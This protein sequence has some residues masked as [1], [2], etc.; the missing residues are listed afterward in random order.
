MNTLVLEKLRKEFLPLCDRNLLYQSRIHPLRTF[1]TEHAR[2]WVKR[3]DE[4]GFGISGCKKRKYAS[5]IPWLK[6]EGFRQVALIGGTRSNHISGFLQLLIE[7]GLGFRL[8]L[9]AEH[10]FQ[11]T[12]NRLLLSLLASPESITFIPSDQWPQ[13]EAIAASWAENQ[14]A[15]TAVIP[16]GGSCVQA[17]PGSSTLLLD[18]LRNEQES[19]IEFDQILIDAGT[20]WMAGTLGQLAACT[21]YRAT[22]HVAM[23]A[24]DAESFSQQIQLIRKYITACIGECP[25][26]RVV[27]HPVPVAKSFGSVNSTVLKEVYSMAREDGILADPVYSAKLFMLARELS[28]TGK[29]KGNV[30]VIHSGGGTGLMGWGEKIQSYI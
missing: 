21:D 25:Q 15:L 9:K 3:E 23:V 5:L 7:N 26:H 1:D 29:L 10:S 22:I 20:G 19:E 28:K 16:E 6:K 27:L 8:F 11:P 4:S 12:G 17:I 13:A 24:G 2:F 18:I 14:P 30:L